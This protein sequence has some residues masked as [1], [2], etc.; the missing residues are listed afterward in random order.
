MQDKVF[1]KGLLLLLFL[2][3]HVGCF[4]LDAFYLSPLCVQAIIPL[5][6]CRVCFQE[7]VGLVASALLLGP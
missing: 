1:C 5:R 4:C 3:W 6:G 7:D 2:F